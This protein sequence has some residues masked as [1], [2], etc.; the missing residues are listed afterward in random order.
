MALP[1][2]TSSAAEA[3]SG[4]SVY[5]TDQYWSGALK[6]LSLSAQSVSQVTARTVHEASSVRASPVDRGSAR[7]AVPVDNLFRRLPP[8][9]ARVLRSPQCIHQPISPS[10]RQRLQT[11]VLVF[12]LR[13]PI[14]SKPQA[15][16]TKWVHI[17]ARIPFS[18][19]RTGGGGLGLAGRKSFGGRGFVDPER[20]TRR[21]RK[22]ETRAK[23][24][25]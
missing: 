15:A 2:L 14:Q 19:L 16:R 25:R 8:R 10:S 7:P 24:R 3:D 6:N 18:A 1:T 13:E 12:P 17:G 11:L 4:A 21:S 22:L 20:V 23:A 5:A 9:L